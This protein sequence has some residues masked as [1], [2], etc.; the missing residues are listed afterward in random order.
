MPPQTRRPSRNAS[1]GL[2]R[3]PPT[4]QLEGDDRKRVAV[5]RGCRPLALRL[6]GREIAG[7]A[8][9][10]AGHRQGV[11]A[12]SAGDPEVRNVDGA[13][14]VEHEIRR[15]D[16]AVDDSVA[17]GG[18]ES[19]RSFLEPLERLPDLLGPVFLNPFL[20]RAA[21]EVLHDDERPLRVLADVEHRDDV[22]LPG[23]PRR[24][25]G[26]ACEAAP[27][28]VVARVALGEQ[29]DGDGAAEDRVGRAIDLAHPSERDALGRAV[30][31]RE[32]VRVDRHA[33]KQ[34]AQPLSLPAPMNPKTR[35]Q[36]EI[37]RL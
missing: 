33:K 37:R 19:G 13:G 30:A 9:H 8:E 35:A 14:S 27:H 7:G 18:I 20:E 25:E 16:V 22:R 15:L 29:L 3:P 11:R 5:A 1:P 24:R 32:D 17:M 34:N 4:E 10:R 2:E 31:R 12:R 21:A 28:G 6:L 23:E 26:L 36:D